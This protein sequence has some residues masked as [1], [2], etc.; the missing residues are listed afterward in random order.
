MSTKIA[1]NGF[2]RV[3]R[4]VLRRLLDTDSDLKVVAV[5]D[6]GGIEKFSL[7]DGI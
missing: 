5:N 1:I 6:L 4:T 2:G 3:G 7:S